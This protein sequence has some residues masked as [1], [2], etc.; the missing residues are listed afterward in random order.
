MS[1]RTESLKFEEVL[2]GG[3]PRQPHPGTRCHRCGCSLPGLTGFTVSRCE[4]T[5]E[6]HHRE[7]PAQA[8]ARTETVPKRRCEDKPL[9]QNHSPETGPRYWT[10]WPDVFKLGPSSARFCRKRAKAAE[11]TEFARSANLAHHQSKRSGFDLKNLTLRR[12][13]NAS[14]TIAYAVSTVHP[15]RDLA[16][17][18]LPS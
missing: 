7:S 9:A 11:P 8:G 18:L 17:T 3:G 1:A 16:R 2:R 12:A 6:V 14:L 10:V 5:G 15:N 4:G 13:L